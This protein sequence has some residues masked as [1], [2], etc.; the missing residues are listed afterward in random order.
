MATPQQESETV[1]PHKY[2]LHSLYPEVRPDD[3]TIQWRGDYRCWVCKHEWNPNFGDGEMSM[4][5]VDLDVE[6]GD[7]PG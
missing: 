5:D 2:N 6:K 1:Q 3:G 7:C 4:C